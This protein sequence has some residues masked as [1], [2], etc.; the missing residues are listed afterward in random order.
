MYYFAVIE[1][2]GNLVPGEVQFNVEVLVDRATYGIEYSVAE[3]IGCDLD[4]D[5]YDELYLPNRDVGTQDLVY[6]DCLGEDQ[7]EVYHWGNDDPWIIPTDTVR[8]GN[9]YNF[10]DLDKDG[11]KE[12]ITLCSESNATGGGAKWLWVTDLNAQ[13]PANLM[14]SASWHRVKKVADMIGSDVVSMSLDICQ[15][16]D[17]DGDGYPDIYFNL[18]N[19]VQLG[20]VIM[21][22][23]FVGTDYTDPTHWNY[24]KIIEC[25]KTAN[26][27]TTLDIHGSMGA[28]GDG[29]KDGMADLWHNNRRDGVDRP[30]EYV[31]EYRGAPEPQDDATNMGWKLS[32]MGP[33]ADKAGTNEI[34]EGS[35]IPVPYRGHCGGAWFDMDGDGNLEFFHDDNNYER[36]Y[37]FENAGNDNYEFRWFTDYYAADGTTSLYTGERGVTATDLDGN[38]TDELLLIRSTPAPGEDNHIPP[39]RVFVHEDGSDEF[40]PE[41]WTVDWDECPTGR[42]DGEVHTEYY[43]GSGDWDK[44]G[45]GEFGINYKGDPLYYFAVIEVSG[46]LVPG[47]VQFNVEVLVD[48]ATYGI[49]YS[50]AEIIGCDLD[51]DGYDELYLPN[52]DVG[53]QDLVYLDCLGEDQWEVYHWGN[54]DPWIIPT[55]TVR[56]GNEYNFCDLDKDGDKELIT[57]CSE[58]NATGGGAKWLWVTDLNAQDPANLMTSASWHRVKKVADMIGS[59]VVSMSLDICQPGD[60]DGDG[61]PDIYFN[62]GNQVQLGGVIMDAEF[63]G[64]D[65]TNPTHWNY[66]KIIECAKTANLDTTLDIHGSMGAYGDGDKDG[67]PDLWHNN[68]RD[69]VDR[70]AE[71]VWEYYAESV[72]SF[73]PNKTQ[74]P[75]AIELA[76]NY[77]N[78]F[79]PTT[80][81]A[82]TLKNKENVE[83]KIYDINGRLVNTLFSGVKV[84]GS[85]QVVWNSTDSNGYRVASG[86]YFYAV[87]TN[88]TQVVK[89]MVLTK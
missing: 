74:L 44:D 88:Q 31:W 64:T 62:L 75:V 66:Y 84:A 48:R 82:Y 6:L 56:Y 55:D 71:Y 81:I 17:A 28:Y 36:T 70:P 22:A 42:E 11:D 50:V 13:D 78:P 20:G 87:S 72:E 4:D 10:C 18:G 46:N 24:Y 30:A 59:D 63:V 51:N 61:Y 49:E 35:G 52:R 40:L 7:W 85:H 73:E 60:A 2:S 86:V 33:I 38:G 37:V 1:V 3:I 29:D 47:E 9:E 23:E 89:K 19:Q 25:A 79:N 68:R 5:G 67:R 32:W 45:N 65:Y 57:L 12:L 14:T 8:Y 83:I 41:D 34:V 27:D 54:D 16:G 15:P 69:G 21:D 43:N 58:S 39:I 77:P 53:T 76:Q 26:L 80:T